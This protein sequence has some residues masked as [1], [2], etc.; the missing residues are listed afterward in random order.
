MS[1]KIF[2]TAALTL[3][4][5]VTAGCTDSIVTKQYPKVPADSAQASPTVEPVSAPLSDYG[6]YVPLKKKTDQISLGTHQTYNLSSFFTGQNV[7]IAPDYLCISNRFTIHTL[8][9]RVTPPVKATFTGTAK[10]RTI[11]KYCI[12]SSGRSV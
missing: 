7:L 3:T 6:K 11:I 2:F 10:A 12:R 4:L 5:V 1:L 8:N 9:K